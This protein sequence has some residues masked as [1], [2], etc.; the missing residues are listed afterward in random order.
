MNL[1]LDTHVFLWWLDDP[2]LLSDEARKAITDGKNSVFI[3]AAVIWEIAIKRSLGKLDAPLDID[4]V[5]RENRFLDLPISIRHAQAIHQLSHL[6]RDPFDRMLIVQSLC[7]G[8]TLVSH[9][10]FVH[11]YDGISLIMA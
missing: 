7:E 2:K 3:S 10:P 5:I 8:L 1:L 6:H 9:D 4:S 11:Q